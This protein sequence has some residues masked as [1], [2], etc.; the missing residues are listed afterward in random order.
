MYKLLSVTGGGVEG[1]TCSGAMAKI[2]W[3]SGR[4]SGGAVVQ[5]SESG[6]AIVIGLIVQWCNCQNM[7]V[8]LSE[9]CGA[10]LCLLVPHPYCL[11]M[12]VLMFGHPILHC[13]VLLELE[14]SWV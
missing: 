11:T 12:R 5:M 13:Y 4:K 2:R 7:V 1:R 6:C 10:L 9:S 3:C 14:C 8:Q